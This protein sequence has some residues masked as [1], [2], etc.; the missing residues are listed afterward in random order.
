M[1]A[2]SEDLDM[3]LL[4]ATATRRVQRDGIRFASTRYVSPVLAA[5]VGEDVTVRY[6]PR[7]LGEIRLF[8]DSAFLCRAI[9]PERSSETIT[10]AD[11]QSARNTR[12]RALKQQLRSLSNVASSLPED[13]RHRP[14]AALSL[15]PS[16]TRQPRNRRDT[17]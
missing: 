12:R 4:T 16:P 6:D 9:A 5:Y 10:F 13:T 17:G 15:P 3:L 1:P 2:H 7:D 11:L 14:A 8:H